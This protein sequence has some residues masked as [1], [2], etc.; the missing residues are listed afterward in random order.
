MRN[1]RKM[2][3]LTQPT[4]CLVSCEFVQSSAAEGAEFRRQGARESPVTAP[5]AE[6]VDGGTFCEN[7]LR[8][9]DK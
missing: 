4:V 5:S 1:G 6:K 2:V 8:G 9:V 7:L 3:L